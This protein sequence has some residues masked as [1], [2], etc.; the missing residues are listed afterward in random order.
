MPRLDDLANV[1]RT[2][3]AG[4]YYTTMDILFDDPAA[5]RRVLDSG[6]LTVAK[7]ASLYNLREDEVYGIFS[8]DQAQAIKV[9]IKK[10]V[11]ADA[12]DQTDVMGAHQH[13]PLSNLEIP[14]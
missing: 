6:L 4:P 12:P 9:T 1:L 2:K 13:L 3:N 10:R 5:Y 8:S 7:V 11:T 14:A